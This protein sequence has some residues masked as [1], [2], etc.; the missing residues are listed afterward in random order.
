MPI[1]AFESCAYALKVQVLVESVISKCGEEALVILIFPLDSKEDNNIFAYSYPVAPVST[2]VV[3]SVVVPLNNLNL[4]SSA[5]SE[6]KP[7]YLFEPSLYL[8]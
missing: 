6:N 1:W 2:V 5:A 4:L 8:Q 7:K 3:G